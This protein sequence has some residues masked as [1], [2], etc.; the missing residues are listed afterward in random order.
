[1]AKPSNPLITAVRKGN[2]QRLR[3]ILDAPART[4]AVPGPALA[5]AAELGRVDLLRMLVPHCD[6]E[7]LGKA[8]GW[9]ASHG[10]TE[11]VRV[12]LPKASAADRA[13]GLYAAAMFNHVASLSVLMEKSARRHCSIA[14]SHAAEFGNLECMRLLL[15][16][17]DAR[18]RG[19]MALYSATMYTNQPAIDL[20][21]PYS[22][23]DQAAQK[24]LLVASEQVDRLADALSENLLVQADRRLPLS[25]P[26]ISARLSRL[27]LERST[28]P[29]CASVSPALRRL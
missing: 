13:Q 22:S 20:L 11:C 19:S 17:A 14:L 4:G 21:L 24:L 26:R 23:A 16:R 5:L 12:L 18:H 7:V 27:R 2:A 3:R 1:M 28:A 29:S 6:R 9:S 25:V 8:L 15:T 10:H